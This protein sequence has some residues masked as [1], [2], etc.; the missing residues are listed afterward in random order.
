M[1]SHKDPFI[2]YWNNMVIVLAMYNSVTIPMAIFY[3]EDGLS[4]IKSETIAMI[5]AL[6]DLTFL[7]DVILTFRTTFLDTDKGFDETDTHKIALHY[8]RG[9]FL[10]DFASSVPFAS[11]VPESQAQIG[12]ILNLLGLLKLLRISRLSQAI[13]SSN[14]DQGTKVIMKILM[15]AF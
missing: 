5:D 12:S 13:M 14:I 9:S 6:V 1:F 8:L 11:F 2:K 4:L 10:I 15:M 7:I 3:D